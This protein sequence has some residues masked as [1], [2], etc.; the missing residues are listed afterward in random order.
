MTDTYHRLGPGIP[1]SR[2]MKRI[3][4]HFLF[5]TVFRFRHSSSTVRSTSVLLYEKSAKIEFTKLLLLSA[6]ERSCG[7]EHSVL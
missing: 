5:F 4:D 7:T 2:R 1:E 6:E 3:L